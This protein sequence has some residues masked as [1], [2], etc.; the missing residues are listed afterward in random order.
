MAVTYVTSNRSYGSAS[1]LTLTATVSTATMLIFFIRTHGGATLSSAS[2][3]G[4][5]GVKFLAQN[6]GSSTHKQWIYYNTPA[7]SGTLTA[8]F[9]ASGNCEIVCVQ[10]SDCRYL[11]PVVAGSYGTATSCSGSLEGN[12]TNDL[13]IDA[14]M[15]GTYSTSGQTITVNTGQTQITN[16]STYTTWITGVSR[17]A[18]VAGTSSLGWSFSASRAYVYNI[19]KAMQY[20]PSGSQV[21]WWT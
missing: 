9:S 18:S 5:G 11:S 3:S 7:A 17:E 6:T 13:Y 12:N 15:F 8:N 4:T 1:S 16:V 20:P 10:L 2:Y 14:L 21:F 19:V